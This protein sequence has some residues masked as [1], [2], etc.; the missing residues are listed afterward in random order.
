MR[1]PDDH[2]SVERTEPFSIDKTTSITLACVVIKDG[3]CAMHRTCPAPPK[4]RRKKSPPPR[5][6][7]DATLAAV[8]K[9]AGVSRSTVVNARDELTAEARKEARGKPP[10][11]AAESAERRERAQR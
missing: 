6:N 1:Q 10:A 2:A 8:A 9:A 4:K 5:S 11:K 3:P 7:P